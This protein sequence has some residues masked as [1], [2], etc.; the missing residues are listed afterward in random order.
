MLLIPTGEVLYAVENSSDIYAYQSTTK[1]EVDP[2]LKPVITTCPATIASGSAIQVAGT[3]FHG[4]SGAVGYG[5]DS[6]AWTNYPIVRIRNLKSRDVQYCR[7]F[8]HTKP[9]ATGN[10][11]VSMGVAT[12]ATIITTNVSVPAGIEKGRAELEVVANG[13]ASNG[14]PVEI[15]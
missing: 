10:P 3:G 1:K 11:V 13:I 14:F 7:T 12:G 15:T 2:A 6:S 4:V 8:N 5:D 9:D